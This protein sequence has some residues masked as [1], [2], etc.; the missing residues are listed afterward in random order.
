MSLTTPILFL[1]FNRPEVTKRAFET[2]RRQ[3]PR[4]LYIAA[5]GPRSDRPGEWQL[6]SETRA[7]VEQVDWECQVKRLYRDQ[8]LGCG[9][10][11][12]QA[13]TWFFENEEE[14][15]ILEDDCLPSDSFFTFCGEMLNR[16]RNEPRVG[17]ISGDWFLPASLRHPHPYYFSKYVQ[18]WGWA[19]YRRFWK[20]YQLDLAG[21]V[22][23][24]LSIIRA[25]NPI[26][27]EARYWEEILRALKSG[28]IDTWDY[29]LM[30]VGWKNDFVHI[31]PTRNLVQNLGYGTNATHTTFESP[32]AELKAEEIS[33]YEVTLPIGLDPQLD[34]GTL[35]FRFLDAFNNIWW[36]HQ[37]IDVTEKLGWARWKGSQ[38]EKQ[39]QRLEKS[40]TEQQQL[41][42]T[43]MQQQ[44][45]S[46]FELKFG[47]VLL[48]QLHRVRNVAFDFLRRR[49]TPK[50]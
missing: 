11:V 43:M 19:T 27:L 16:F 30:F 21:G 10:A 1:I 7:A 24:W 44:R 45:K 33:G 50:T 18:I 13:I 9:Q 15:I 23:D 40:V 49:K 47:S 17:T 42:Q 46:L 48:D 32:L 6:C 2:I 34:E 22:A 36:L 4:R 38:A 41:L 35:F 20:H 14:G 29:Q 8:N 12:S 37:A 5:D 39:L 26:P 25:K 28:M 31:A 3:K